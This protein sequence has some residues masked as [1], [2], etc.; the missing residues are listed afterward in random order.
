MQVIGE[1]DRK[2]DEV[3]MFVAHGPNGEG[4]MAAVSP[5]AMPL[6]TTVE[7]QVFTL[8]T[9]ADLAMKWVHM[10]NPKVEYRILRFRD[11]VDVTDQFGGTP[12]NPQ[13]LGETAIGQILSLLCRTVNDAWDGKI[14]VDAAIGATDRML[15]TVGVVGEYV[16]KT[17]PY[18][19]AESR[20]SQAMAKNFLESIRAA[21]VDTKQSMGRTQATG[22][23]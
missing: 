16:T 11:R 19:A 7:S 4:V 20:N 1:P 12:P 18:T 23:N 15:N 5:M 22:N 9:M 13:Q 3:Y 6:L 14:D 21:L 8:K 10:E 17:G 2:I